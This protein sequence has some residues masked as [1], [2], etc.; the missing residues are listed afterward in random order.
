MDPLTIG[1]AVS[2]AAKGISSIVGGLKAKDAAKEAAE[3]QARLTGIVRKEEVR[4]LRRSAAQ[5]KGAARANVYASNLQLTGTPKRYVEA[6]DME[7][8]REIAFK[9][10]AAREEQKAILKSAKGAGSGMIAQ[11]IGDL[12]GSALS[13]A[14]TAYGS[15]SGVGG[16]SLNPV[17]VNRGAHA[18]AAPRLTMAAGN[19]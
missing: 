16:G 6:L 13:A 8:M 11:G 4:Q 15:N 18:G 10:F 3:D 12:F 17:S 19:Q 1:L 5:E 2:G 7:N 9:N 14:T